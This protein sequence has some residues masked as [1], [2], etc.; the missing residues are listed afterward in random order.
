M[1]EIERLALESRQVRAPSR[2]SRLN[3]R[4]RRKSGNGVLIIGLI[5]LAVVLVAFIFYWVPGV[6]DAVGPDRPDVTISTKGA[7]ILFENHDGRQVNI[8][9][10][11]NEDYRFTISI[12]PG[13]RKPLPMTDFVDSKGMRFNPQTMKAL[14]MDM[15]V[16]TPDGGRWT[17]HRDLGQ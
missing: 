7:D 2:S 4:M 14:R 6:F 16:H 17:D 15:T 8:E 1:D 3:P 9:A 11:I 12:A 5:G 13:E 10:A